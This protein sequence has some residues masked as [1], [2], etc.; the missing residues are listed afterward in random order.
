M[1]HSQNIRA[2]RLYGESTGQFAPEFVHVETISAR[3]RLHDWSI[4]P[5]THPGIHQLLL[6]DSGSGLLIAD[7][8]EIALNASSLIAVPSHCVHGFRF[9]P[10]SEG[11]VFSFAIE[12][13]HDPRLTAVGRIETFARRGASYALLSPGDRNLSRLNWLFADLADELG[14]L[15]AR[16][17]QDRLAAQLALILATSEEIMMRSAEPPPPGRKE[18][19][20][21]QFRELVDTG[22][23][24]GWAVADYAKTL[25]TTEPTLNRACRAVLGKAP[26]A[27]VQDRLLLEAMRQLTYT[28]ANV[29]QIASHLGFSDPA[30]FARFFK[31]R[32]GLTATRFREQRA[33]LAPVKEIYQIG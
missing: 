1:D 13:L 21:L 14:K 15:P 17:M 8:T 12:L 25:G 16:P 3:S 4:S 29:S 7:G 23:R 24:Q 2:Y 11:W 22:Y 33:W 32:T 10:G 28:G 31:A 19:L 30:Y 5:H 20:A 6:V 9:D 18:A 27:L 26:G